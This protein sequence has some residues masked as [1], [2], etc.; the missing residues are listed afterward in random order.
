[1]LEEDPRRS[2]MPSF[3][4]R[5]IMRLANNLLQLLLFSRIVLAVSNRKDLKGF[6]GF[7]KIGRIVICMETRDR[8]ATVAQETMDRARCTT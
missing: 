2:D 3:P 5:L 6:L 1:L 7:N 8:A 4:S